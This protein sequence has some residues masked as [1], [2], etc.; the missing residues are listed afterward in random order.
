MGGSWD[1]S[2][3]T[4]NQANDWPKETQKMCPIKVIQIA[5][6]ERLSYSEPACVSIHRWMLSHF[7]HVQLFVTLW[8]LAH[9]APLSMEFYQ[10]EYWSGL[11]FLLQGIF[12]IQGS[13]PHL[14]CL[15]HCR[16]ILFI[17]LI[18]SLFASLLSM[19]R[20][21][22]FC[23]AEGP[24]PLSLTTGLV[25]SIWCFNHHNLALISG[26]KPKMHFKQLQAKSTWDDP[27]HHYPAVCKNNKIHFSKNIYIWNMYLKWKEEI[28]KM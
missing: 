12:P 28:W 21:V 27:R 23:K 7:S 11:P 18:N 8:T 6:R 26:W 20:E 4:M 3:R 14:L 1:V 10:Q 5:M 2:I 19:F 15:L 9:Q 17:L 24:G 16:Q 25:A 13:K 22:F